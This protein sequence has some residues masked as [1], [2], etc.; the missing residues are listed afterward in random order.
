MRTDSFF[1]AWGKAKT[2]YETVLPLL[3]KAKTGEKILADLTSFVGDIDH[4]GI[5]PSEK[6]THT[7]VIWKEKERQ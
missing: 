7:A 6:I 4:D 3:E 2:D 1:D 5:H